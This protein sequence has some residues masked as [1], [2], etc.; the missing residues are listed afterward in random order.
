MVRTADRQAGNL[1]LDRVAPER[2][3]AIGFLDGA[4]GIGS[5]L[6]QMA[7]AERGDFHTVRAVDDPFPERKLEK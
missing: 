4:A 6:L 3:H 2:E 1:R 5:V 7:R